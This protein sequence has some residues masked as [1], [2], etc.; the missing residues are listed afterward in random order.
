M[1][2]R[3]LYDRFL[4]IEA[5]LDPFA[6]EVDG[7]PVWER[8]RLPIFRELLQQQGE[9]GQE[10]QEL[11]KTPSNLLKG[12][13]LLARNVVRRNPFLANSRDL[14]FWGFERRKRLEDDRHWDLFCDPLY[15]AV[16]A[17]YLHVEVPHRNGHLR[18]AKT[19]RLRYL[20]LVEYGGTAIRG[21]GLAD[22]AISADVR[23]D[24]EAVADRLAAAFDVSIDVVD[25]VAFRLSLRRSTRRLYHRFLDRVDPEL[26]FVVVS[27]QKETFVEVCKERD[28]PVVELQH[29]ILTEYE[30]G[31]PGFRTKEAYPD[32]LFTFGEYWNDRVELPIPDANVK[33]VGYE[34]FERQRSRLQNRTDSSRILFVSQGN[35]GE[36]LS[37]AAIELS[38][39][40]GVD[41]SDVV[42]K[43]HPGEYDRWREDYP[44]LTESDLTVVGES[45][46]DLYELFAEAGAQVGVYS[47]AIYEGL[48]FGLETYLYDLP[49]VEE[50]ADLYEEGPARLVS[51]PAEIASARSASSQTG[52]DASA[53]FATGPP[54]N[55][56]RAVREVCS[57][58]DLDVDLA[59]RDAG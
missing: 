20:D 30:Y 54:E 12:A 8:V 53:F 58:R 29:G 10:I 7:V 13:Y 57:E 6:L 3:D 17:D 45:G 49:G 32:Y 33:T 59:L 43:L 24:L 48:G 1:G 47:T 2:Y 11:A 52:V 55:F 35:V 16:D 36:A 22:V 37:R 34:H 23:D 42:Y 40:P 41:A 44:W 39:L 27:F 38:Q 21:A 26:A 31:Y 46:P 25:R 51:S 19:R 56:V 14:L 15:E 50:L 18:P 4:A 9:W 28:V 5:D